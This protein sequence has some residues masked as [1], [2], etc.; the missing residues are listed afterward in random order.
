MRSALQVAGGLVLA[1][2]AAQGARLL[3]RITPVLRPLEEGAGAFV[4]APSANLP[5]V[6]NAPTETGS[7]RPGAL[8][9][10]DGRLAEHATSVASYTLRAQLDP[11]AHVIQGEGTLA[12]QNTS[13][14]P[15]EAIYI[16]LYLNAFKSQHSVFQRAALDGFRGE[17]R[18]GEHGW[19]DVTRF[20]VR[21]M[22]GIDVWP[23]A[24][25]TSPDDPHDQTDI[26]VALPRPVAP[27]EQLTIDLAWKAHLPPIVLRTGYHRSFHM[28]AQW[29]PKIAR[30]EPDGRW[31]HFPFH[32]L[33]EFHADFGSYDVTVDAPATFVVG[34]TGHLESEVRRGDR[35]ER[36]YLQADVHDFAFAAWDHFREKTATTSE[37]VVLRCLYPAGHDAQAALQLELARFGLLHFGELF[38]RY[39]YRTLTLVHPPAG[40]TEAGGMEY[41]TLITT[42]GTWDTLFHGDQGLASLTLHEIA[43]QWFYGLVATDEHRFPFLDEGLTTWAEADALRTLYGPGSYF[44]RGG[45][46]IDA[47]TVHRLGALESSA[48]GPLGQSAAGF[49]S[50]TEY[51]NQVYARMATLLATLG[52]VYGDEVVR[53]AVGRYARTFRFAHPTPEDLLGVMREVA[54]PTAAEALRSVLFDGARV[55][56]AITE[57]QPHAPEPLPGVGAGTASPAY[58]GLVVVRRRGSLVLPVDV[59][60]HAAD[61]STQRVR[62]EATERAARIVYQGSSPLVAAVVDP[63][64]RVLLDE[65]LTNNARSL[66]PRWVAPRVLERATFAAGA[67]LWTI[68]P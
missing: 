27:G 56:Y 15:Q 23:G 17:A 31:A 41:P 63:E 19:I 29:F 26:R 35:I 53:A 45:L 14:V 13:R 46:Q 32:R 34:A 4:H 3:P 28:V 7:G 24:L 22:D 12:W 11:V 5:D 50:G 65:D 51:G 18:P 47:S 44:S 8:P 49:L 42:G 54:G 55:D 21:E 33:S 57:I 38:G 48:D 66:R 61:G 43:H 64:R 62:W 67:A 30:L 68:G 58:T 59:V 60:F 25:A 52:R 9:P 2:S 6:A 39:P 1:F 10:F 37:G 20:A 40:A 16:H 36:R